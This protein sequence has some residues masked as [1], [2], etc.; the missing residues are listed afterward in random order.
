MVHDEDTPF[1][2]LSAY[3]LIFVQARQHEPS[4]LEVEWD[5]VMAGMG[6]AHGA[7]QWQRVLDYADALTEPWFAL[8]EY[9]RALQG[10]EWA[11]EAAV[12]LS[13]QTSLATIHIR[14]GRIHAERGNFAE[15]K[16]LLSEGLRIA[17]EM[18]NEKQQAEA[19]LRL[20]RIFIENGEYEQTDELLSECHAYFAQT[21]DLRDA[22]VAI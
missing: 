19:Q 7:G 22:A 6:I 13:N 14:Q 15:A 16:R 1:V 2:Q 8:A 5:N 21:G 18:G 3:F 9:V 12:A 10:Y 4:T 17:E 11:C 20:A